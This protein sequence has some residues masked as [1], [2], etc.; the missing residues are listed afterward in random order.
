MPNYMQIDFALIKEIF[1]RVHRIEL[2]NI[3]ESNFPKREYIF[4][5]NTRQFIKR[6]VN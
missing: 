6:L 2:L 3:K 5:Y 1:P 4:N